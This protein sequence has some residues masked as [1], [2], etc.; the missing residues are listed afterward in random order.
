MPTLFC[1]PPP[2]TPFPP[3]PPPHQHQRLVYADKEYIRL[4]PYAFS[5]LRMALFVVLCLLSCGLLL[6]VSV[7][8]PQVFTSLARMR[9]PQSCLGRA[10]YMLVLVRD[11]GSALHNTWVEVQVT[12]TTKAPARVAAISQ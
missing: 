6:V 9:L 8:F 2:S 10:H 11:G 1:S 7:W 3:Q 12:T 5:Y 4:V